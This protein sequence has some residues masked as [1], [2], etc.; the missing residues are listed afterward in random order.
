MLLSLRGEG[1]SSVALSEVFWRVAPDPM[2]GP[3]TE[4][5]V[6]TDRKA[7]LVTFVICDCGPYEINCIECS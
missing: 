2:C 5:A 3:G 7:L 4:N 1:S 6:F